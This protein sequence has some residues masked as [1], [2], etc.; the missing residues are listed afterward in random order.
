MIDWKDVGKWLVGAAAMAMLLMLVS[1]V[2]I[3]R[4]LFADFFTLRLD[5]RLRASRWTCTTSVVSS[6]CPSSS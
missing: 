2:I 1:G 4:K 5:K 6:A 3:H